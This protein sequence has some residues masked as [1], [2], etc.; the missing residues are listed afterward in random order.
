MPLYPSAF[1][2]P[3]RR[4]RRIS[5]FLTG[6]ALVSGLVFTVRAESTNEDDDNNFR[7]DVLLCE[8]ALAHVRSCCPSVGKA[9]AC[10]Y[11]HRSHY[12]D[13]GCSSSREG[14]HS[15]SRPVIEIGES[16]TI[17]RTACSAID[18]SAMQKQFAEE[19]TSGGSSK[20]DSR[21]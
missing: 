21:Y 7:E 1:S 20:C 14:S 17:L 2:T 13:C 4:L 16:K 5:P 6:L 19:N 8:E 15:D 3:F 11:A 18:C 12:S 10:V 9:T